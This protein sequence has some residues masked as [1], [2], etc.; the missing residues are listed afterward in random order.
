MR[1]F[2]ALVSRM[3]IVFR[4]I[5]TAVVWLAARLAHLD[6]VSQDG[7]VCYLHD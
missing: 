4:A 7:Q 1:M 3:R 6:L 2:A 5:L